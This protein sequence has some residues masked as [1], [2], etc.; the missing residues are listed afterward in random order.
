MEKFEVHI[1][2]TFGGKDRC[3]FPIIPDTQRASGLEF[4]LWIN[5]GRGRG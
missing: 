3:K 5:S 1:V 4:E 2:Q